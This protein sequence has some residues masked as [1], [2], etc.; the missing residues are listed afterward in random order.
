ML[1][2]RMATEAD[3][4]RIF[5]LY[6]D[7]KANPY[8]TYDPMPE[9][10][11]SPLFTELLTTK[12]LFVVIDNGRIAGTFRLIPKFHRQSHIVYIGSFVID[13]EM[14]GKV[15]GSK[16]MEFIKEYSLTNGFKRIE[17]NVI[18]NN[19]AAIRLYKKSG[20]EIE[21]I[22]RKNCRLQSTGMY[23]D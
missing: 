20:F 2:F 15:I 8:L 12:T 14:Q 10:A 23:F 9:D 5:Q 6:M 17:L 1:Q 4:K 21:G 13:P 7:E 16:S 19:E 11:F 18:V 22:V 3:Q